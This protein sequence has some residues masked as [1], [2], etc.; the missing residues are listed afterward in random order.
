MSEAQQ[1]S[2]VSDG[3]EDICGLCGE[4]GADKFPHPIHWPGEKIPDSELVHADC[5][6][7]E[8]ARAH[9]ELSDDQRELFLRAMR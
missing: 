4:M 5:E 2:G 3:Q 6:Q 8:C 9:A 1:R 7:E